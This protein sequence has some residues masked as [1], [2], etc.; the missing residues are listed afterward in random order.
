MPEHASEKFID[1]LRADSNIVEVISDYVQLKKQGRNYLGLCPFHNEKSPSFSVSP[2]KQIFRCFGCG[3]GGNVITFIM[4]V[5][6]VPFYEAIRILADKSGIALPQGMATSKQQSLS[7]EAQAILD[8][9][10]WLAKLYHHLIKHTKE[11]SVGYQYLKDR[12]ITDEIMDAFQLGYAPDVENFTASFLEKKG[13]HPQ[14]MVK[15]GLLSHQKDH[16][17]KDRFRGRVIFPIR[18]HQGKTVAFGG[19]ILNQG[20]PKYLNSPETEIFHKGKIFFNFDLARNHIRKQGEA[21]LFEGYLDVISAYQAGIKNGVATLGTSLTESQARL[22]RRYVDTVII[23]Y[24][25]DRAGI[26]ATNKAAKILQNVGCYV[27]IAKLKQG[28]DPDDYIKE[29]G[30]ESFK[31]HVIDASVTYMSFYL[32]YLKKDYNLQV[33]SD[34]MQYVEKA[35]DEIAKLPKPF[36]RDHYLKELEMNFH[37]SMDTLHQEIDIRRRKFDKQKDNQETPRHTNIRH[38]PMVEK[39]YPAFQNAERRLIALMIKNRNIAERVQDEIGGSFLITEH[40]VI[41]TYLYAYYEE[42]HE[43]DI[44]RFIEYLPE[45]DL[46]NIIANIAMIAIPD[47]VSDQE[48]IDYINAV[49]QEHTKK[50]ELQVLEKEQKE[51]EKQ[52]NPILAAQIAMKILNIKKEWKLN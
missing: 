4:E 8:A 45:S 41:V 1:E 21:I 37:I 12:G 30:N 6:G 26:E 43:P 36:E 23:C 42:G 13:F 39:V 34:Q 50:N 25:A 32:D 40:Q 9:N 33:E 11:G 38:N 17:Y 24:D 47:D 51:A 3:K 27:K 48:I 16:I 22:M 5:E 7:E 44:S 14:T 15:A 31:N 46:K 52:N 49:K 19:R 20:E 18:N 35:L 28:M 10:E 2:D 29:Y